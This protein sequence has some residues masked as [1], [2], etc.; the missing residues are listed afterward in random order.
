M[1]CCCT[2]RIEGGAPGARERAAGLQEGGRRR[3]AALRPR[4]QVVG[5]QLYRCPQSLAL[6]E[7]PSVSPRLS[8]SA[9]HF[10]GNDLAQCNYIQ[11]I[12]NSEFE[13]ISDLRY[14]VIP[15]KIYS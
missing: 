11:K 9:N 10:L 4:P 3:V 7:N 2:T 8:N 15:D 5:D 14:L 12:T 6:L 1:F 13:K